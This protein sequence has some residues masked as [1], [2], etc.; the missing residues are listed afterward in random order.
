MRNY[1][2]NNRPLNMLIRQI[3]FVSS[4]TLLIVACSGGGRVDS[5]AVPAGT[6]VST[7]AAKENG[8]SASSYHYGPSK[9]TTETHGG[10][11]SP[12]M[13]K[14]LPEGSEN[15]NTVSDILE[16]IK[17]KMDK[18]IS[19]G[20]NNND[21]LGTVG[22]NVSKKDYFEVKSSVNEVINQKYTANSTACSITENDGKS[23][24]TFMLTT[25]TSDFVQM[26]FIL[27]EAVVGS[28][29]KTA[30]NRISALFAFKHSY[31]VL[32]NGTIEVTEYTKDQKAVG[33]FSATVNSAS[34]QIEIVGGTFNCEL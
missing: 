3:L 20:S 27:S 16:Q 21:A 24:L 19:S 14:Y 17:D 6:R 33:T 12:D 8:S 28:Y 22:V 13:D 23:V 4:L 25:T 2:I 15:N 30:I 1:T 26:A 31:S 5:S 34:D 9:E 18:A 10:F 32:E 7:T 11:D 29:D